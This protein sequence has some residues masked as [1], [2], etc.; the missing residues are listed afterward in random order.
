[1]LILL[2]KQNSLTSKFYENP[3][4]NDSQRGAYR[5]NSNP[6][7]YVKTEDQHAKWGPLFATADTV[8]QIL[9]A[10]RK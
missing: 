6:P 4:D 8:A 2:F 5:G 10:L 3:N 7:Q 9:T 1:M